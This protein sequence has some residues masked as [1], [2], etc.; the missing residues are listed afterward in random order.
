MVAHC[1]QDG[2]G[3]PSVEQNSKTR[4]GV[5]PLMSYRKRDL[6][7]RTYQGQTGNSRLA[8]SDSLDAFSQQRRYGH[9]PAITRYVPFGNA[10]YHSHAPRGI[11]GHKMMND[12]KCGLCCT[13]LQVV[14][15]LQATGQSPLGEAGKPIQ[16]TR[17]LHR[18]TTVVN[19]ASPHGH[20]PSARHPSLAHEDF[21]GTLQH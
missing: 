3:P 8:E 18:R 17:S 15:S 2:C 7:L 20:S 16:L 4:D 6:V 19:R 14:A 12:T 5:G 9:V 10:N 13:G 11:L 1:A 21:S